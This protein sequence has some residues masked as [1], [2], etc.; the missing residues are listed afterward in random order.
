MLLITASN[1]TNEYAGLTTGRSRRFARALLAVGLSAGL[2]FGGSAALDFASGFGPLEWLR[3]ADAPRDSGIERIELD[4]DLRAPPRM[5][6]VATLHG[7]SRGGQLR[8]LLNRALQVD[9]VRDE[10]GA[11]LRW[12]HGPQIRSRYHKEARLVAIEVPDDAAWPLRVEYSGRGMDGSEDVDW[13]GILLLADDEIRMSKQTV[14]H[15]VFD[16]D[17]AGPGAALT[18]ARLRVQAPEGFEVHAPGL[19]TPCDDGGWC[20]E[21]ANPTTLSVF[22]A[23][24]VRTETRIGGSTVVT[25][26]GAERMKLADELSRSSRRILEAYAAWWGPVEGQTLGICE[27]FGRGS[28]YNWASHGIVVME[29]GSLQQGGVPLQSLAHEIGHIWWGQAVSFSGRGERFLTEGLAEYAAWRFIELEQ[30]PQAAEALVDAARNRWLDAVHREGVDPALAEVGFATPNYQELAYSKA[31]LA[32]R[33]LE[34]HLGRDG[35]D[36]L[37]R[38]LRSSPGGRGDLDGLSELVR[39]RLADV[40]GAAPWIERAG[41]AHIELEEL[42]YTDGVLRGQVVRRSMDG[43]TA[44]LAPNAVFVR[45]R[46]RGGEE[47]I[48]V[49]FSRGEV[50]EFSIPCAQRPLLVELDPDGRV[51]GTI[52]SPAYYGEARLLSSEPADGARDVPLGPLE[53]RFRFAAPLSPPPDGY[54]GRVSL[55]LRRDHFSADTERMFVRVFAEARLDDDGRTLVVMI[56]GTHPGVAY[57]LALP[58]GLEDADGIPISPPRIAFRMED[59]READRPTVLSTDPADGVNGIAPDLAAIRIV[60]SKPMHP[61]RGFSTSRVRALE[62]EGWSFPKL[63]EAHWE[64][65]R[66]LIWKLASPLEAGRRYGMPFGDRFRDRDGRPLAEWDLKFETR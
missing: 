51:L 20:F 66:T 34:R 42:E 19:R 23:P 21:S 49:N 27:S 40:A 61:G 5:N 65:E 8:F 54:A 22:A 14:F 16:P 17:P 44:F 24:R 26:L 59:A 37:L 30:G 12:S 3:G 2:L 28:S 4:L 9:D 18:T 38:E 47:S 58:S 60:F 7:A 63:G 32:W 25:L 45:A 11:S 43:C 46:W 15:P 62:S 1:M 36:A 31:P 33:S 55:S 53:M 13:M 48:E 39:E 29:R 10:R 50:A 41:H 35:M 64:D 52:G 56:R 6:A 57:E